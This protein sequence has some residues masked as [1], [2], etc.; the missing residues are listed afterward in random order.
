[1]SFGKTLKLA[2][3][4]SIPQIGLGTWL[5]EPHEVERA[6]E[7]AVKNGYRHL[8]LAYIY[9]NQD[10]VGRALKK[11]IP[12]VVKREELFIT[13]KL[14][15]DAHRPEHVEKQLDTTLSQ[16]GLDY[17]DLYLVHWPVAFPPGRGNTPTD[18]DGKAEIDDGVTLVETW[19]AM[20][21]LLKTGKVRSVG[22]SNFTVEMVEAITA[23]TGEK[24][25]VNQVEAHPYLLQEELIQHCKKEGIHLTAYSPLGNNLTNKPRLTE[26]PVVKKVAGK[27]GA[28]TGQ[29]LVAWG[30]QRGFSVI[31]KSVKEERIKSNFQQVTLGDDDMRAI[32]EIGKR[33]HTRFNIPATY[34]PSWPINVFGEPEE[35]GTPH[36]VNVGA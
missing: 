20:L 36:K 32:N 23:A 22:V 2:D 21:A 27:V 6:V 28:T 13:S 19:K 25:V 18:S 1:M 33:E 8:D 31:P 29:V 16:L 26:H 14:W 11:V 15:N 24:P 3:G 34:D 4:K 10:E 7:I 9:G 12:S 17:L 35:K 5:S 30:S